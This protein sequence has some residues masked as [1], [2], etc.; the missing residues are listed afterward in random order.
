MQY[1][2]ET[3]KSFKDYLNIVDSNPYNYFRGH[4]DGENWKLIP[5][6]GR[7]H[8]HVNFKNGFPAST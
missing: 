8:D 7:L 4:A 3:I 2:T 6:L 5:S 1:R